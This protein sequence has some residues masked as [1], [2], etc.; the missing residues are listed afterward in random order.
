MTSFLCWHILQGLN[1][2]LRVKVGRES[3]KFADTMLTEMANTIVTGLSELREIGFVELAEQC[4]GDKMINRLKLR[5]LKQ[6]EPAR[7]GFESYYVNRN[8]MEKFVNL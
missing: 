5:M 4:G 1:P 6:K 3:I 2:E 7:A 8:H